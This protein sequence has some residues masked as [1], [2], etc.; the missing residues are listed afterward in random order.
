MEKEAEQDVMITV[1]G[2]R[3]YSSKRQIKEASA[4]MQKH[5]KFIVVRGGDDGLMLH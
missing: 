1:R 2:G 5:R 3:E 4:D